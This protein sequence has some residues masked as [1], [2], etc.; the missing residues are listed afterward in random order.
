[1]KKICIHWTAGPYNQTTLDWEHYHF[2]VGRDGVVTHGLFP[3]EANIPP[4]KNGKYAAHC[5][6]GN[7]NCIGIALRGMAG[8]VNGKRPGGYP[9][10]S[11][12]CE[13]AFKFI[14]GLCKRYG[15]SVTPE[16]VFTHYEFGKRNPKSDS[17]GKIDIIHLP[18]WPSVQ[19][20]E[21]GDFIREKVRWYLQHV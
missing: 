7:S 13:S 1:M 3:P 4:L 19:A 12:Q 9:L 18:P 14:A 15:I 11:V 2:T 10:T 6:G 16:T 20:H 5:G 8:F 21:V 17:F